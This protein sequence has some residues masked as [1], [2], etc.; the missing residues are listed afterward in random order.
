M[1]LLDAGAFRHDFRIGG[2]LEG[3]GRS[4]HVL[5]FDGAR[6]GGDGEA[7]T[8]VV[9]LD[10]QDFDAGAHGRIEH[11]GVVFEVLGHAF[12]GR[13]DIGSDVV[14]LQ[15]GKAVVPGGAVGHQRVP[16]FGAPAFGDPLA[17][18]HDMRNPHGAEVL[19]HCD[20]GLAGAD[21]QRIGFFN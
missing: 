16:A 21:H 12:L 20:A 1:K 2:D 5:G 17:F 3:A 9:T 18:E 15:T 13:E 14:E 10:A 7:R 11:L 19:A 8:L 6:G 4:D